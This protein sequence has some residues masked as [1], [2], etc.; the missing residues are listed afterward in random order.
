MPPPPPPPPSRPSHPLTAPP[1][2]RKIY[3]QCQLQLNTYFAPKR[4]KS[5]L[6]CCLNQIRVITNAEL[7][8]YSTTEF[9]ICTYYEKIHI[10]A[11]K[12]IYDSPIQMHSFNSP[13]PPSKKKNNKKTNRTTKPPTLSLSD[14]YRQTQRHKFYSVHEKTTQTLT[15]M[16]FHAHSLSLSLSLSLVRARASIYSL[17]LPSFSR[18]YINKG[19]RA[20]RSVFKT[21]GQP[22]GCIV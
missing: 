7:S 3:P 18:P 4:P 22:E 5:L 19:A 2:N 9:V 1:Q 6:H 10:C 17:A 21:D 13:P 16:Y 14:T 20:Q 15:C 12:R 11:D 8:R